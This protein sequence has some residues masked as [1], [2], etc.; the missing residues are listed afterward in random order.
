MVSTRAP[1]RGYTYLLVLFLVAGLGLIAAGIGQTWQ[2]RAQREREAELI[3]IGTEMAR[4]LRHYHDHSPEGAPSWPASLDEL[5]E[6][7]RFPTPQRHLRRIYRDPMTGEPDWGLV[8]A[9]G[10]IVGIHSL[11]DKTPFRHHDLP[12]E[13]GQGAGDAT[14]YRD[15]VF[16]PVLESAPDQAPGTAG[17]RARDD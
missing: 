2:A 9:G 3:A 11:S 1:Q 6:D 5:V 10:R 7:H 16:R 4:A 12:P 15:W 13:L 17:P 14:R 8:R